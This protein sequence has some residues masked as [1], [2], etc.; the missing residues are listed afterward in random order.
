MLGNFDPVKLRLLLTPIL[1]A[2]AFHSPLFDNNSLDVHVGL[3]A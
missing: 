2:Y 1:A 3:T